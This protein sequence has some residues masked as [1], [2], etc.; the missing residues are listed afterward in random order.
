MNFCN[1][2]IDNYLKYALISF[3]IKIFVSLIWRYF[4]NCVSSSDVNI[5]TTKICQST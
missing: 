1:S 5:I 3:L 2:N 4:L